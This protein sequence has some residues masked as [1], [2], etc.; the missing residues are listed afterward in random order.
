MERILTK[1]ILE[2]RREYKKMIFIAGPRQVGKTTLLARI[3]ERYPGPLFN[4]DVL[5]HRK[6]ITQSP[7]DAFKE[8]AVYFDEIHKYPRWKNFL[9]GMFDTQGDHCLIHVTGSA[10]LDVYR[11]GGDSLM[12]RYH[13][14]RMHP[15]TVAEALGRPLELSEPSH[16]RLRESAAPNPAAWDAWQALRRFGGFPEPFLAGTA[17]AHRRWLGSRHERLVREDIRDMSRVRELAQ[18]EQM[19]QLLPG[20]AGNPLSLNSLREELLVSHD[21]VRNWVS[22]LEDFYYLFLVPPYAGRLARAINKERKLYLWDWSEVEDAGHRFENMV[23]SHL[24]KWCHYL[25]DTGLAKADLHYQRDKLKR[26]VDFLITFDRKPWCLVEAK[27]SDRNVSKQALQLSEK[28]GRIPIYQL[29][30][31]GGGTTHRKIDG[32]PCTVT[33]AAAFCAGLV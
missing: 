11:R 17:A 31:D 28:A 12:G 15:V 27:A 6:L 33:S 24:L 18:L 19:V 2:E 21:A 7:R 8:G 13:L 22:T 23:A 4:W 32:I 10:R 3:A 5:E 29:V 14:F 16:G 1:L 26:E 25:T 9:K 30:D 20:R